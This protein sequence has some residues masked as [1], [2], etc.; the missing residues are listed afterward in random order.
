MPAGCKNEGVT[1]KDTSLDIEVGR[2]VRRARVD[3]AWS[4]AELASAL[5]VSVSYVSLIESGRRPAT[6]PVLEAIATRLGV[7]VEYLRTGISA[8]E[9]HSIELDVKFAE[10]ALRNGDVSVALERFNQVVNN[11]DSA[12]SREWLFTAR[13]GLARA[14]EAQGSLEDAI[15]A[16]ESLLSDV[17]DSDDVADLLSLIHI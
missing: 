6:A 3:K 7:S 8:D 16:Y 1:A 10:I 4:Q 12:A 17:S 2:R 15:Q 14:L 11:P 5:K 13:L 9:Q